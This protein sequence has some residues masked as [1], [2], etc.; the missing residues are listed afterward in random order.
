MLCNIQDIFSYQLMSDLC[1]SPLPLFTLPHSQ[2]SKHNIQEAL[3]NN[4]DALH[5]N[6]QDLPSSNEQLQALVDRL[7]SK[8][9]WKT[10]AAEIIWF[11]DFHWT[12]QRLG[13]T[14]NF[15]VRDILRHSMKIKK[16][17]EHAHPLGKNTVMVKFLSFKDHD[18][19]GTCA[20]KLKGSNPLLSVREDVSELSLSLSLS[21]THTHTHTHTHAHTH[22]KSACL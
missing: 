20:R 1:S 19:V 18:L 14:V 11:S 21:L 5:K 2:L 4:V 3:F 15:K 12:A 17:V 7:E 6:Y 8:I 22:T 16:E 13:R 9:A 10:R